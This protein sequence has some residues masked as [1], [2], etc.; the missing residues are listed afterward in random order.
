MRNSKKYFL[1]LILFFSITISKAQFSGYTFCNWDKITFNPKYVPTNE[2]TAIVFVSVRE[3]L[4]DTTEFMGYE[5]DK[6]LRMRYFTIYFHNRN[7]ICVPRQNLKEAFI[8]TD[9]NKDIVLYG[10]GMGKD[11]P[12]DVDR[13][14]RLTR[15]Y[16]VT[17]VMFDWPTYRP[18]LSG[19]KNYRKA[20]FQS[21][22]V[23]IALC[24]LFNELEK[25][26]PE[27]KSDSANLSLLLH[28]LGNRLLKE[29]VT[30]NLITL[31]TKLFHH[32]VLNAPCVRKRGHK[33]WLEKL[34]IQDE[35]YLTRNNKDR[36]LNLARLAGFTE[37]LGRHWGAAKA[38]NAV[39]LNF[40]PVLEKE[41]NYFLMTN[42]LARHP[43][44][45]A[46]Y[47]DIF[48]NRTINFDNETL[49]IKQNNGRVITLK[50]PDTEGKDINIGIS[51]GS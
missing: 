16:N 21:T 7:W 35:I 31:K 15:V 4:N 23:S 46:I 26:K 37:Q 51:I 41:H 38:K 9:K 44:I 13:A 24:N 18:Y 6:G 17:T 10:E 5:L 47:S 45:K 12:A 36:T 2:D 3:Y 30:N 22:R 27:V 11:F 20:R 14:T 29:A 42:V 43:D 50:R 1:V 39:Y 34:N 19:G 8:G 32:I 28:S 25:I 33:K 48:H 49:F 40:S